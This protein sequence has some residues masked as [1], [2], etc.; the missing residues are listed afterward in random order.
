MAKKTYKVVGTQPVAD[1]Q[2][3][4]EVTFDFGDQEEALIQAGA[5]KPVDDK[6]KEK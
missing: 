3:G 1:T 4:E 5:I 2:P 6:T